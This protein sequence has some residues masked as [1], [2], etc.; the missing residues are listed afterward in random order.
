MKISEVNDTIKYHY[1]MEDGISTYKGGVQ[2][3]KQLS[4]PKEIIEKTQKYLRK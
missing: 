1:K 2:V 4:Y 3:L